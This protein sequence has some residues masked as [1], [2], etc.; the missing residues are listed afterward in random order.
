[1]KY[2]PLLFRPALYAAASA[3]SLAVVLS[4]C[5]MTDINSVWRDRDIVINGV[6]SGAEWENARFFFE[7]KKATL[8]LMNDGDFLYVRISS[9]DK[10]LQRKLMMLG[11]TIWV[12]PKG[13]KSRYLGIHY[14]IGMAGMRGPEVRRPEGEAPIEEKGQNAM[15]QMFEESL[16]NIEL[17][18]PG[19][20]EKSVV[21]LAEA[22]PLGVMAAINA[23][24]GNMVYELRLPLHQVGNSSYFIT[25]G[26]AG[27]V[28]IGFEIG[29]FTPG[30]RGERGGGGSGGMR[31]GGGDGVGG[32]G[33]MGRGSGGRG[34]MGRG[35]MGGQGGGTQQSSSQSLDM[36]LDVSLAKQ[37]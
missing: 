22:E 15:G 34:G 17:I 28:G 12:N 23:E 7:E 5:G 32:M 18:G 27:K 13:N 10:S 30:Q 20:K 2:I 3:I 19:N 1:M 4:G 25:P 33:G 29:K 14:P 31:R 8:G 9:R 21:A 11:L 35:G 36:W 37:P 24:S 6:D 16:M 26:E